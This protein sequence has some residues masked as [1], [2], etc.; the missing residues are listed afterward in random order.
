[1]TADQ[2]QT[3]SRSVIETVWR[4]SWQAAVIALLVIAVQ[5]LLRDKLPARWRYNLWLLVLLRLIVPITP[6]AKFSVFNLAPRVEVAVQ[7]V[8]LA[9]PFALDPPP[10]LSAHLPQHPAG[11]RWPGIVASIWAAGAVVML[12]RIAW[13]S[14]RLW[15]AIRPMPRVND[16]AVVALLHRCC[17]EM[18]V[19]RVPEV[20]R[21]NDSIAAPALMGFWRPRMLLPAHVL[22]NF[23]SAELRLI[24]LHEL[25]HLKRRDVAANW[26]VAVLQSLHWFNPILHVAFARLRSDRELAAD[27]MVLSI[28]SDDERRDYGHTIVKLV[29]TLP[30][31]RLALAG[32]VGILER[33]H[34]LRRRIT[35]IA[36]FN[37]G[38]ARRRRVA[39]AAAGCMLVLLGVGLTD[40]V[41]GDAPATRPS[42]SDS[43]ARAQPTTG[44]ALSPQAVEAAREALKELLASGDKIT[45]DRIRAAEG[46]M[47]EDMHR[48]GAFTSTEQMQSLGLDARM[49]LAQMLRDAQEHAAPATAP[50]KEEEDQA[51]AMLRKVVPEVRFDNI[52]F[53]DVI[54]FLRDITGANIFVNWRALEAAGIDRKAPLSSRLNNATFMQVLSQITRDVGGSNSV[55]DYG[56]NEGVIVIST[57]EELATHQQLRSFD[58]SDLIGSQGSPDAL[59]KVVLTNSSPNVTVSIYQ[60][61]MLVKGTTT[62]I[63]EVENVLSELRRKDTVRGKN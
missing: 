27:D 50:S 25:A 32:T 20:L 62:Q 35:M 3:L 52:P 59:Q 55:V 43:A 40:A 34:P 60:N 47:M 22:D 24:I 57:R 10:G 7:A 4:S 2:L 37:P 41:R 23:A 12:L 45:P 21:S 63:L 17:E 48:S 9:T 26:L 19:P 42:R 31:R 36:R 49:A 44:P 28:T 38:A 18:G 29:E 61:R 46:K 5:L 54:D 58:V 33:A 6:S 30:P 53:A 15:R 16:L 56:V 8:P 13:A 51:F 14:L 1:M 11:N 39:I